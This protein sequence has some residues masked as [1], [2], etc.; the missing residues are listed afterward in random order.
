MGPALPCAQEL[1]GMALLKSILPEVVF[2]RKPTVRIGRKDRG[3]GIRTPSST[4]ALKLITR[5]TMTCTFDLHSTKPLG[6]LSTALWCHPCHPLQK[7]MSID[8]S[9]LGPRR[10]LPGGCYRAGL[11][12]E[13]SATPL[14]HLAPLMHLAVPVFF[15]PKRRMRTPSLIGN[16]IILDMTALGELVAT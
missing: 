3:K 12:R 13:T 8:P 11:P 4:L 10:H 16:V 2:H 15:L 5:D 9:F 14:L 1:D 7:S 6:I